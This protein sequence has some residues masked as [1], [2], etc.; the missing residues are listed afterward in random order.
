[1]LGTDA[2][3]WVLQFL[4][5]DLGRG[6]SRREEKVVPSPQGGL[7]IPKS[8]APPPQAIQQYWNQLRSTP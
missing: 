7:F 8:S 3:E 5:R 4:L 6:T 2:C 1:M